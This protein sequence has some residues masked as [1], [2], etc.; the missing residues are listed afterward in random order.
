MDQVVIKKLIKQVL[1]EYKV[2]FKDDC[3]PNYI[4]DCVDCG[5]QNNSTE[6]ANL[7]LGEVINSNLVLSFDNG[8]NISIDVQA[9]YDNNNLPRIISTEPAGGRIFNLIRDDGSIIPL[10]LNSLSNTLT[11]KRVLNDYTILPLDNLIVMINADKNITLPLNPLTGQKHTIKQRAEGTTV[12]GN[13]KTIDG[14]TSY[15]L[16][17]INQSI[18]VVYD[19]TEWLVT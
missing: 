12:L 8:S 3:D 6:G 5:N 16:P 14:F 18:T 2:P 19:G 9:L 11:V 10:N 1:K 13:S 7:V 15:N 17:I 4:G